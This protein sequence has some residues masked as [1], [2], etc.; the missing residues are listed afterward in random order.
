MPDRRTIEEERLP[1]QRLAA[2]GEGFEGG[3]DEVDVRV[4]AAGDQPPAGAASSMLGVVLLAQGKAEEAAACFRRGIDLEPDFAEAHNNLG[5]V[6][7]NQGMLDE[8]M[9]C[10]RR[11]AELKPDAADARVN[12]GNAF[13]DQRK[14]G[15]G[16]QSVRRGARASAGFRGGAQQSSGSP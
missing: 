6:F 10:F 1:A 14:S 2:L 8:A 13:K 4:A 5:N 7:R 15:G 12:L 9:A 16:D 11:A 3:V